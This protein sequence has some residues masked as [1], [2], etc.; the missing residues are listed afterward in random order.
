MNKSQE[1]AVMQLRAKIKIG[2][3]L[4]QHY[5]AWY[6]EE[7][8]EISEDISEEIVEEEVEDG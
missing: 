4:K 2:E 8:K 3:A 6:G 7:V 1:P 5:N